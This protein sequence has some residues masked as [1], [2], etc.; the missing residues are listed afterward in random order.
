M[1]LWKRFRESRLH[2]LVIVGFV[3]LICLLWWAGFIRST[4]LRVTLQDGQIQV[5]PPV[6]RGAKGIHF[7]VE[8]RSR[9]PHQFIALGMDGPAPRYPV[10]DG[11]AE[12]V[13]EPFQEVSVPTANLRP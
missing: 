7:I 9:Q 5:E 4:T 1:E 10:K 2:S 6:I 3:T 11:Q 13:A 12:V 8:N